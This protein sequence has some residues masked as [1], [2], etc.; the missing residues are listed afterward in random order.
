MLQGRSPIGFRA[1]LG[2]EGIPLAKLNALESFSRALLTGVI[3]LMVFDAPEA[4]RDGTD[5][6]VR[7]YNYLRIRPRRNLQIPTP[8]S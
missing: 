8:W 6:K 4:W 2:D 1:A 5:D 3:P 7:P